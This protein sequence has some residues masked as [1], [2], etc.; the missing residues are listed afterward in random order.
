MRYFICVWIGCLG[1]CATAGAQSVEKSIDSYLYEPSY[2]LDFA[3][4]GKPR[5]YLPQPGDVLLAYNGQALNK[6]DDLKVVPLL[7]ADGR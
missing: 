3:A 1:W 4:H 5:A 7:N 2:S 6:K